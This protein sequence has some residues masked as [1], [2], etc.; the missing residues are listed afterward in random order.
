M[1]VGRWRL[2]VDGERERYIVY[3]LWYKRIWSMDYGIMI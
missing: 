2:A 1:T 3:G